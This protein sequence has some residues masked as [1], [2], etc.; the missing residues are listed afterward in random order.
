M[1]PEPHLNL[2]VSDWMGDGRAWECCRKGGKV[3]VGATNQSPPRPFRSPNT[4]EGRRPFPSGYRE[5]SASARFAGGAGKAT[6]VWSGG[7]ELE[8]VAF[9]CSSL[10][11]KP[12]GL[13]HGYQQLLIELLIRLV[14]W[15]VDPVKAG[16]EPKSESHCWGQSG[17]GTCFKRKGRQ[18]QR[19]HSHQPAVCTGVPVCVQ[20]VGGGRGILS[21]LVL[22]GEVGRGE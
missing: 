16:M 17:P 8:S 13:L 22:R 6:G 9:G 18:G 1:W 21:S 10:Y 20:G 11:S 15:N 4:N 5:S 2:A 7:R 12:A 19:V 14:G 3:W